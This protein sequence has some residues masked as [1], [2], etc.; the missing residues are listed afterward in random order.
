[1][2]IGIDARFL[3][4]PQP[5]GFKTYTE[6][7]V[8]ALLDVDPDNEYVLYV[9]RPPESRILSAANA[10]VRI[11]P[12]TAPF[13]GMPWREQIG[14]TMYA[15]RDR[16]DVLHSLCLTAPLYAPCPLIVT[17]HDTIW[18]FPH[19]FTQQQKRL[20]R[21]LMDIY[22]QYVPKAA[23]RRASAVVTVSQDARA[24]IVRHLGIPAHRV[25]VTYEAAAAIYRRLDRQY[26]INAVQQKFG[27]RESFILAIGSSDPRKNIA[28]LLHA[29]A[30]LPET[31]RTRHNLVIVWTHSLLAESIANQAR[32]CGIE[33][34][35]RFLHHVSNDDLIM[36]YNAAS[37]FVFPSRYEGFGLPILEAMACGTPVI[38]A[39]NSSIPEVAGDAA[40]LVDAELPAM[41]AHEM[42]R[43]L[44]DDA[45]RHEMS[46]RSLNRA[47]A[48]SWQR[49]AR[50]TLAVYQSIAIDRAGLRDAR[51]A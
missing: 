31:M 5:G 37:F 38:A 18:M 8:C 15:K 24:A 4:H 25:F 44:E 2:R 28:T 12:G 16:I 9:D 51:V 49:C 41:M 45:L 33:E 14:L 32:A 20:K 47:T 30:L 46:A 17:I 39:N 36:L 10:T 22:Y 50:E 27:L 21:S 19:R 34:H 26:A 3:T 48:F 42:V 43:L 1:M 23:V 35:V 40:I 6:Q 29:Y 13:V 7:L 11:V